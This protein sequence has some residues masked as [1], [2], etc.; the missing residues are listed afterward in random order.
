MKN[1]DYYRQFAPVTPTR[2]N[3]GNVA[4]YLHKSAPNCWRVLVDQDGRCEP[5]GEHAATK[6]E[7][8]S[9][10]PQVARNWGFT[11]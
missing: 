5:S 8:Y 11:A 2:F 4:L 10:L 9:I 6:A 1:L 7:C 3:D